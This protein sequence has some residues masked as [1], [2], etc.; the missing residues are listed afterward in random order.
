MTKE[1]PQEP[2]VTFSYAYRFSKR[3]FDLVFSFLG[4][5]V[6]LPVFFL[7]SIVVLIFDGRPIFFRQQRIGQFGRPFTILKF[8]TMKANRPQDSG[9]LV[10]VTG[11]AR[12]TAV[13]RVLRKLKLDELPQLVNVLKGEMS[14]VGPRPEVEHY[15][16]LYDCEQTKLLWFRP[17]ITDPASIEFRNESNLLAKFE[18]PEKYY[19]EQL[20]PKKTRISLEYQQRATIASDLK[21]ILRTLL[22]AMKD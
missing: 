5:L 13:G 2:E 10:T 18:S 15:V 9:N 4:L 14:L 3:T 19:V 20:I 11:D 1:A 16:R 12:I 21:V 8:R 22:V 17:G 6:L 7:V